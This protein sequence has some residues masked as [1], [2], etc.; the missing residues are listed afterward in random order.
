MQEPIFTPKTPSLDFLYFRFLGDPEED[1][2]KTMP[3]YNWQKKTTDHENNFANPF[4]DLPIK[5]LSY[6]FGFRN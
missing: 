3:F 5:H 4:S 1:L 2:K 6:G